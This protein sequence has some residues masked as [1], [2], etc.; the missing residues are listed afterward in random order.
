[1]ACPESRRRCRGK[2]VGKAGKLRLG[3]KQFDL[4]GGEAKKLKLKLS[5]E[6]AQEALR[7]TRRRAKLKATASDSTG[8]Q[9]RD[10]AQ[11]APEAPSLDKRT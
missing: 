11:G 2:L 10:D 5:D 4:D 3:R 6:G 8:R 7:S 1:M 9:A